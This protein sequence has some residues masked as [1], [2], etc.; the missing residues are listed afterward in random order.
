MQRSAN[1][2]LIAAAAAM[3]AAGCNMNSVDIPPM[4]G[5]SELST[6]V[7]LTASPDILP[8][9]GV[10]RAVIGIL[11]RNE[12]GQPLPNV[13][14][15]VTTGFGFLSTAQ[16]STDGSGRATLIFTAPMT[17]TPGLDPGIVTDIV[18]IPIGT[19]FDNSVARSVAI[20]LVAP[21]VITV[22]GAPVAAFTFGP[23]APKAGDVVLF[24]GSASFD[25]DGT[26]VSY[27]WDWDD[28]DTH[29]FGR[30]Q[31]HDFAA[32]GTYFV[33]LTV[34]DNSG[35]KSTTTRAVTVVE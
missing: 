14:L 9:D 24:D 21:A 19:N 2:A 18:A 27:E 10:S 7:T 11:V 23:V 31:D 13:Q 33:K 17:P 16:V 25:P 1:R 15:R 29:G 5:P 3:I 6:S 30:N 32:P 26:I 12:M 35:L 8:M 4:T 20:R 34:T 28:G 22:P